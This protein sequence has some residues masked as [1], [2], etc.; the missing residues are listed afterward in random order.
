MDGM[1][2]FLGQRPPR[3]LKSPKESGEG[4]PQGACRVCGRESYLVFPVLVEVVSLASL[5][6]GYNQHKGKE[7]WEGQD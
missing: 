4:G 5:G 6:I 3:S 2:S 7:V 1:S